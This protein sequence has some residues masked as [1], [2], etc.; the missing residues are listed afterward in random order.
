MHELGGAF[1]EKGR[2][3]GWDGDV[4]SV[5]F[6]GDGKTL[7]AAGGTSNYDEAYFV[8]LSSMRG[9]WAPWARHQHLLTGI[10]VSPDGRIVAVNCKKD[11]L[12]WEL[13][14]R[15]IVYENENSLPQQVQCVAFSRDGKTLAVGCGGDKRDESGALSIWE[16]APWQSRWID[17]SATTNGIYTIAFS[18]RRL[19]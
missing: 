8:D 16:T 12:V 6:S 2:F 1:N 9:R 15:E 10:A 13:D 3:G 14:A 5:A 17:S 4:R 19:S 18:P 11:L 7:V